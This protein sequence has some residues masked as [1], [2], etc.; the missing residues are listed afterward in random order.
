MKCADLFVQ[1][2]APG[3]FNDFRL[4]SKLPEFLAVGRPV[5]LPA[6]NVGLRLRDGEQ[7]LLLR[8]GAPEEIAAKVEALLADPALAARL[9]RAGQAFARDAWRW[10][11]QGRKL[12]DLLERLWRP[13]A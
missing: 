5:V 13:H 8:T 11:V 4:P 6:A 2:G 3:A 7:A 12:A 10:D 1:P 9:G